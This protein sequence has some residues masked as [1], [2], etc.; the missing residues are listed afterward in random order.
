[1]CFHAGTPAGQL[2]CVF[3][4]WGSVVAPVALML[5]CCLH[6]DL[7]VMSFPCHFCPAS[8]GHSHSLFYGP[9]AQ[10]A[11]QQT[12]QR[13]LLLLD[14]PVYEAATPVGPYPMSI[15]NG[16]KTIPVTSAFWATRSVTYTCYAVI[17]L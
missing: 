10:A 15:A 14:P 9:G 3:L 1:M 8:G 13:P 17:C 2:Y 11:Q 4:F 5:D 12:A 7:P 6:S 16:M